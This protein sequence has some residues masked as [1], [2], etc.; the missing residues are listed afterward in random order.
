MCDNLVLELLRTIGGDIAEMK[1]EQREQRGRLATIE[2]HLAHIKRD[3]AEQ[4]AVVSGR[5]DRILDRLEKIER[6][7]DLRDA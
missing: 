1:T 7:L 3:G 2:R 6:R 5:F 4:R